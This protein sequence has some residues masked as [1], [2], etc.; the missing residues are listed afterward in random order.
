MLGKRCETKQY[1]NRAT[2]SFWEGWKQSN[3]WKQNKKQDI[4]ILEGWKV[5]NKATTG[6]KT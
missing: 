6:N 3:N 4:D 2:I 5:G 1:G